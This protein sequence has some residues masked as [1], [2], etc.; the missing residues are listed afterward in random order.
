MKIVYKLTNAEAKLAELLWNI[1]PIASMELI[2]IAQQEFG[3]KKSTT[4]S[5]LK[6]LIE[7]GIAQNEKSTV[8]MLCTREQF[9]SGQSRSYV[10][11]TFGGSLPKFI[12]SFIGGKKLTSKQAEELRRL[13]DEH[14]GGSNG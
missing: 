12:T 14:E 7:K 13:I 9:I 10:E 4:F 6:I 11:D 1:A 3:W 2:K 8:T 5:V